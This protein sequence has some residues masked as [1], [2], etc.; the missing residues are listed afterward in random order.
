MKMDTWKLIWVPRNTG[1]PG[2][3]L[4]MPE[5]RGT[6]TTDMQPQELNIY[7]SSKMRGRPIQKHGG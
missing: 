4:D 7:G 6:Q 5:M 2:I 3:Q 1:K